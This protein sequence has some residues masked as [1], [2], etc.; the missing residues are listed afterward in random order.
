MILLQAGV[1]GGLGYGLG[2]GA[3][4]VFFEVTKDISHLRGFFLPWQVAVGTAGAVV[5]IMFLASV[6][7]I[8]RVWTLEPAIVFKS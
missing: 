6:V 1:V 2:M 7:S 3:T 8:R 5:V 4:S